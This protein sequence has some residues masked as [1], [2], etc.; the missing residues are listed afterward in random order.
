MKKSFIAL[1]SL[2]I[3]SCSSESS[4]IKESNESKANVADINYSQKRIVAIGDIHGDLAVAQKALKIAGA[5]DQTNNWIGKDLIVVQTGDQIDRGDFDK[6]V[7]D[8]F[9]NL[10]VQAEK[11]GGKVYS[12]NGNHEIMNASGDMRYVTDKSYQA[13]IDPQVDI[14]N[15]LFKDIPQDKRYR[16]AQFLP[17]G[18]YAKKLAKRNTILVLGDN[19]FVH[20]GLLPKHI[21]YGLD[22][23]NNEVKSWLTSNKMTN[24]PSMVREEDSAVWNRQY[25]DE[26]QESDCPILKQTLS[27]IPAKR[28]I[29]G[30]TVHAEGITSDC[31][32]SIWRIDTGMSKYYN[33]HPE[34]LE[35]KGDKIRVLK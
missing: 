7:I 35:I 31:S 13:F 25:A 6:E 17:G 27:M 21:E 29:V 8:F 32:D 2:F 16:Y 9:D 22:K 14:S 10:S 33:G 15:P 26:K 1:F 18:N 28:M 3:L 19:V 24:P 4:E 12:L 20:G 30:H 5:I 34:V 23:I 11:S